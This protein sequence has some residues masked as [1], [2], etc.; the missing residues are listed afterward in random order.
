M[1]ASRELSI[2]L[3]FAALLLTACSSSRE[4]GHSFE[5]R[6]IEGVTTA[7][8]TGG[9]RFAEDLFS[10]EQV[11]TLKQD[12]S[13][14]ESLLNQP[15]SMTMDER[16]FFYIQDFGNRRIAVFDSTGSF[17]YSIGGPGEGP[18]EFRAIWI[19]ELRD[20]V[21]TLYDFR[22]RRTSR[23]RLDGTLLETFM[24]PNAP[25]GVT[26]MHPLSSGQWIV[27]SA[28]NQIDGNIRSNG[29]RF[30][31]LDAELD[32][33]GIAET[34]LVPA[35]YLSHM[36]IAGQEVPFWWNMPF[37]A[38]PHVQYVPEYGVLLATGLEPVLR[39]HNL[40]GTLAR[41]IRMDLPPSSVTPEERSAFVADLDRQIEE[42]EGRRENSLLSRKNGLVFPEA[43]A[44]WSSVSVDSYG[45][46]WL[47]V[48]ESR[49]ERE[50]SGGGYEYHVLSPEG[51]YLG[52]TRRPSIGQVVNGH[53]LWFVT[54]PDTDEELP[55]VWRLIPQVEGFRYP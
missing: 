29:I 17:A 33:V 11:L 14:P 54:D 24:L 35:M 7:I 40:D 55:T 15:E 25:S 36:V 37:A 23:F 28:F 9:P 6:V 52:V 18:G 49:E 2:L 21:L 27:I 22:L 48:P 47:R 26:A 44:L 1:R 5:V 41:E 53:L 32:T 10:Y 51:E 45:Y 46:I 30:A 16:G 31:A 50:A 43:K 13:Q 39:W 12:S 8:N 4:E 38:E 3:L 19:T 20:D 34:P 42:A